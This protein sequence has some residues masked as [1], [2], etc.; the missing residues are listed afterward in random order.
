MLL[1]IA[2]ERA[3]SHYYHGSQA[4]SLTG[5]HFFAKA[6]MIDAPERASSESD[7]WR[8]RLLIALE[9]DFAPIRQLLRQAPDSGM[10]TAMVND[11]ETCLEYACMKDLRATLRQAAQL[12]PPEINALLLAV[13]L[14]RIAGAP[15]EY[16]EL[17][18]MHYRTMWSEFVRYNPRYLREYHDYIAAHRP[19][20]F[21]TYVPNLIPTPLD[22]PRDKIA[23]LAPQRL[24]MLIGGWVSAFSLLGLVFAWQGRS[25]SSLAGI[26]ALSG[27]T[28]QGVLVLT[29][30]VGVGIPRYIAVLWPAMMMTLL[31]GAGWLW[32]LWLFPRLDNSQWRLASP[33]NSRD[34]AESS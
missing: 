28:V 2:A 9:E 6:G 18:W 24:P 5:I 3:Y 29:A 12:S 8:K 34:A 4:T 17:S 21:E 33:A 27:L 11:Y 7:P 26:A 23:L 10:R 20:P 25:P 1:V 32:N 22:N 15:L 31:F 13:G 19:L 30:L 16:L 14:E